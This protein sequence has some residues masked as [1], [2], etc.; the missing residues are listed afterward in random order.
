[1]AKWKQVRAAI[2][3]RVFFALQKS[4]ITSAERTYAKIREEFR[5]HSGRWNSFDR[6]NIRHSMGVISLQLGNARKLGDRKSL[7]DA[8][9]MLV[10]V[11]DSMKNPSLQKKSK[12]VPLET[13]FTNKIED[14]ILLAGN[15]FRGIAVETKISPA[16]KGKKA[17]FYENAIRDCLEIFINNAARATELAKSNAPIKVTVTIEGKEVV[18]RVIDK[19]LG[20]DKIDKPKIFQKQHTTKKG[21]EHGIG[22]VALRQVIEKFHK[23]KVFFE[24]EKGNGSTF[25][26]AIPLAKWIN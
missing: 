1:M 20:I 5:I 24:S 9:R 13:F 4:E 15:K 19:G 10:L 25:G 17:N 12:R 22:L 26:F 11:K 8:Q 16:L 23:G 18:L 21:G 7:L 6:H 3:K 14:A 2:R